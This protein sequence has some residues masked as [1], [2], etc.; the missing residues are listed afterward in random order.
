[1]GPEVALA[2]SKEL[3]L[4]LLLFLLPPPTH[5]SAFSCEKK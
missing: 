1:V 5:E 3:L 4:L 2:I